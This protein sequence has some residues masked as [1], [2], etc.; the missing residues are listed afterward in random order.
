MGSIVYA[1]F[2]GIDMTERFGRLD[3]LKARKAHSGKF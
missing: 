2:N 1:S 3:S